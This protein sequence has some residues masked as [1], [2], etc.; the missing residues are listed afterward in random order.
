MAP[1]K[2]ILLESSSFI[3]VRQRT[4]TSSEVDIVDDS[5]ATLS[6][7]VDHICCLHLSFWA[8]LYKQIRETT[9]SDRLDHTFHCT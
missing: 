9:D 2:S 3:I 4:S 5:F 6:L 1:V 7:C 8:I